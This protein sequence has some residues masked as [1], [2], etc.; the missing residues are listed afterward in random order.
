M[1]SS[2][3][4]HPR[5]TG[6]ERADSLTWNPHKLMGTT[7]Q[8]SSFH[9]KHDNLLWE[10]NKMGAEYLFMT[11]KIYDNTLDIG[12]KTIQCGRHN[13]VFKL[14]LQWRARGDSGFEKRVNRLMELTEYQ[15]KRIKEQSDKFHLIFEPHFVNVC[16]WYIPKSLR[17]VPHDAEK[18]EKLGVICPRIKGRMM[19]AGTLMVGYQRHGK[20]PNFFRSIISQDAL[21]EEDI[22]FML[23]EI[24][25]LGEDL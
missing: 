13:D 2:K 24:D 14:W 22:D 17:D 23:D 7:L 4:R 12:D 16:F 15:V 8:C 21:T 10:S 1:L 5:F 20:I 19:K 3:Y 9:V 11:D 25:R 6:V 18:E